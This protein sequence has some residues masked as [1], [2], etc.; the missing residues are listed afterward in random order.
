MLLIRW[1]IEWW[2]RSHV[3]Q[4]LVGAYSQILY[5]LE[6]PILR[7]NIE[8]WGIYQPNTLTKSNTAVS[9]CPDCCDY[10]WYPTNAIKTQRIPIYYWL[11]RIQHP[12]SMVYIGYERHSQVVNAIHGVFWSGYFSGI[13]E[14]LSSLSIITIETLCL[15]VWMN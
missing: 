1:R 9:V 3:I 2:H 8:F 7:S 4:P 6:K 14:N 10:Q 5:A 13:Y 11:N 15:M 12:I